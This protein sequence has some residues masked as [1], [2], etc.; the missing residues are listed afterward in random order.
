MAISPSFESGSDL[1]SFP[2]PRRGG[3]FSLI[4][5]GVRGIARRR[6]LAVRDELAADLRSAN[7]KRIAKHV[8]A[9]LGRLLDLDHP[10]CMIGGYWPI[11][12]EPDLRPLFMELSRVGHLIGLP[13]IDERKLPLAFVRW[14][15]YCAMASGKFGVPVPT[16][17]KSVHVE[18]LLMPCV[19]FYIA[20]DGK[21]YR[22]GYGGGY[23]DRTL[24]D[25]PIKTIGVAYSA[26]RLETFEPA[27][28]DVPI[29]HIVTEE[30]VF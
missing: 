30:G 29:D 11:R 20:A 1:G 2:K 26:V 25:R 5:H 15:P 19:G 16:S 18:L 28:H 23:Y 14:R 7:D 27:P 6:L 21:R 22:L 9:L 12:S 24:A 8:R 3:E 10:P 4:T 17:G 13:L